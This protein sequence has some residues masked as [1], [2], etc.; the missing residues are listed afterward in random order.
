MPVVGT[1]NITESENDAQAH[2]RK[3]GSTSD[4]V[5]QEVVRGLE[6][7]R[8]APG[9]RLIESELAARLGVGRNSVREAVQRLAAEGVVELSAY[10]GATIRMPSQRELMGLLDIAGRMLG[11]LART[12][13]R[14]NHDDEY[15]DALERVMHELDQPDT[16]TDNV[17]FL[18]LRRRFYNTLLEMGGNR[19]LK[20]LITT[21]HIPTL[22]ARPF[23]P[24]L[25]EIR[26]RDYKKIASAVLAG[27][28]SAA[29]KAGMDHV[30]RVRQALMEKAPVLLR[31]EAG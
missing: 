31:D 7:Q 25:R 17:G 3:M 24:R 18:N 27:D 16:A 11:L 30:Q 5:F 6:E 10:K 4:L 12:A 29:D 14:G 19:D 20:R 2:G 26:V 15:V 28:E 21:I 9:Q 1:S 22:Y 8:Y 23:V 13:A